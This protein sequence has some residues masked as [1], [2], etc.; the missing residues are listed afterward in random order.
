MKKILTPLIIIIAGLFL[1]NFFLKPPSFDNG[2]IVP[3][4]EGTLMDGS[5]F[6]LSELRGKYV[7]LDFWGSWCPPCLK[8]LPDVKR[9][10]EKHHGKQFKDAEDFVIVS[11]ALEKS[12]RH[13]QRIIDKSGLS[14]PHHIVDVNSIVM[15]SSYAQDFDVKDLPTKFLI[16]PDGKFMGTNLPFEEMDRILS[17]RHK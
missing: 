12:D 7:L 3:E 1:Y 10:Y 2:A 16:N 11:I 17:E 14:W 13:T 15:L 5:P 4:V 9:L 6:K 8:E